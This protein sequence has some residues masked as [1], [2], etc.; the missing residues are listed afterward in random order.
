MPDALRIA[1]ELILVVLGEP[2]MYAAGRVHA[3]AEDD[4]ARG[5]AGDLDPRDAEAVPSGRWRPLPAPRTW[6]ATR[7]RVNEFG[8]GRFG[9]GADHGMSSLDGLGGTQTHA[10]IASELGDDRAGIGAKG[11]REGAKNGE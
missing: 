11:G 5:V 6:W 9:E 3:A 2:N 8:T 4:N 10:V 1:H 7:S